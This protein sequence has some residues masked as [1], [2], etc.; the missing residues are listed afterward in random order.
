MARKKYVP[1][2][3]LSISRYDSLEQI[4]QQVEEVGGDWKSA[5]INYDMHYGYYDTVEIE[6]E[7]EYYTKEQVAKGV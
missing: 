7:V 2:K 6:F 5:I 4:I 1:R 3:T